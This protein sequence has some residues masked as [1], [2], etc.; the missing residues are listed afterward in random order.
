MG[1]LDGKDQSPIG[2]LRY[3]QHVYSEILHGKKP[4]I[5]VDSIIPFEGENGNSGKSGPTPDHRFDG[6]QRT[7]HLLQHMDENSCLSEQPG[8]YVDLEIAGKRGFGTEKHTKDGVTPI[9]KERITDFH[10][11]ASNVINSILSLKNHISGYTRSQDI[12]ILGDPS[13]EHLL[14]ESPIDYESLSAIVVPE[15]GNI[16]MAEK[17]TKILGDKLEGAP[18]T[19]DVKIIFSNRASVGFW[20]PV[21]ASLGENYA[22]WLANTMGD[23]HAPV[24]D[25][26]ISE[27]MKQL[28]I[29]GCNSYDDTSRILGTLGQPSTTRHSGNQTDEGYIKP[30]A[31]L[32]VATKTRDKIYELRHQFEG[33]NVRVLPLDVIA[34]FKNPKE[35]SG[36]Y[37]A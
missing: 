35:I 33:T 25:A 16:Q 21:I 5:G 29:V 27:N 22:H 4:H 19:E 37:A 1:Y 20:R 13:T 17:L 6:K 18:G 28:N 11:V 31:T 23:R 15:T 3:M 12:L 8:T 32:L 34:N 30:G 14:N 24:I 10:P 2:Q 9:V 36:T 7:F 26:P